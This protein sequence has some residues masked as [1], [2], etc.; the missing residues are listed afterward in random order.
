MESCWQHTRGPS[1]LCCLRPRPYPYIRVT[2]AGAPLVCPARP[3]AR[4]GRVRSVGQVAHAQ[5][6]GGGAGR[7]RGERPGAH[8]R[9]VLRVHAQQALP[10]PGQRGRAGRQGGV[11]RRAAQRERDG[12]VRRQHHG[13]GQHLQPQRQLGP[14]AAP[15][16]A[17]HHGHGQR[18]GV[19]QRH[20]VA[21]LA[22]QH[23]QRQAAGRLVRLL[24]GWQRQRQRGRHGGRDLGG[25]AAQHG[26]R[27]AALVVLNVRGQGHLQLAVHRLVVA[28]HRAQHAPVRVTT[29]LPAP[30]RHHHRLLGRGLLAG[31]RRQGAAP[32]HAVRPRRDAPLLAAV[33]RQAQQR[34]LLQRV[35]RADRGPLRV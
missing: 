7:Q 33:V 21:R 14:A 10:R 24:A 26:Q 32:Q 6:R 19:G 27:V 34:Q 16:A 17:H 25:N 28:V 12:A 2:P 3:G 30:Q 13:R 31:Q 4:A 1:P 23:H 8:A 20:L 9:E 5:Q 11:G 15:V 35:Q 22:A 18:A 29:A